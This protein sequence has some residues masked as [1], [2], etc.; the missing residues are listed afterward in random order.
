MIIPGRA[1]IKE[2]RPA[3]SLEIDSAEGESDQKIIY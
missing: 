1:G 3:D 2:K